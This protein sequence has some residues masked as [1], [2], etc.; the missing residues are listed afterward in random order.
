MIPYASSDLIADAAR[1]PGLDQ[2]DGTCQRYGTS[3]DGDWYFREWWSDENDRSG[4]EQTIG[5]LLVRGLG[6]LAKSDRACFGK[7]RTGMDAD[8]RDD[9]IEI[10]G[11]VSG[12]RIRLE[13][14]RR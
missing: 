9:V 13:R 11:H 1:K 4:N 8:E 5:T 7:V 6:R 3:S 12:C 14:G 10:I 2:F